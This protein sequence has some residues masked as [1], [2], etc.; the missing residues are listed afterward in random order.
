MAPPTKVPKYGI[1]VNNAEII[2]KI[3]GYSIPTIS[4][5]P[6]LRKHNIRTTVDIPPI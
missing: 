2:P 6:V 5:P 1:K 4:N 3:T